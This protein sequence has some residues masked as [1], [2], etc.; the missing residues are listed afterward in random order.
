M[1]AS[2]ERKR[3]RPLSRLSYSTKVHLKRRAQA[4]DYK[5]V[6]AVGLLIAVSVGVTRYL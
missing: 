3:R 6:A 1:P 2:S 4:I 5:F